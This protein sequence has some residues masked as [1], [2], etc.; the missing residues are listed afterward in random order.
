[1]DYDNLLAEQIEH[2]KG[3]VDTRARE[4]EADMNKYMSKT[5]SIHIPANRNEVAELLE[6]LG[7]LR[8][9]EGKL[10]EKIQKLKGDCEQFELPVPNITLK[11]MEWQQWDVL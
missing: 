7:A 4:I 6:V 9:E 8:E 5:S 3:L 11:Q 2:L 10:V 1:M